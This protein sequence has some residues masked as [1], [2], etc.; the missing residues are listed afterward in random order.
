MVTEERMKSGVAWRQS[1][2]SSDKADGMGEG[3]RGLRDIATI[4]N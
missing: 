3:E 4:L 2:R 1:L